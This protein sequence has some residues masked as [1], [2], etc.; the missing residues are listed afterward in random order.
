[1][2]DTGRAPG[3]AAV[4]RAPAERRAGGFRLMRYFTT[5]TLV[6]F[7]AVALTLFFLQRMEEDFFEQVQREHLAYLAQ[8][9][10][11]L[12]RQNEDA[13]RRSLLAE[14]EA[15]HVT[16]AQLVANMLWSSDI[17]PFVAQAR[18]VPIEHC[19]AVPGGAP[20]SGATA[21]PPD[22]RRTCF[23]E[24]GRRIRA[25]SGF[26][27]LDT[28]AYAAMRGS[29]V[30]KVKVFDLRGITVYSSEH[31]Q[32]GEDA[33]DNQGWRAAVGGRPAS[34]LTRRDKF[35]AFERVV[36]NR[37]LIST[38]VPLRAGGRDE[39]VGVLEIYA[40]VT[41]LLA[42]IKAASQRFAEA[43]ATNEATVAQ[44]ARA[45]QD[46][47]NASSNRFL[48]I[49]GGLLALLYV[50]SL[51]IVHFGQRII[52]KQAREH[53]HSVRREQ[54]WH[55]EKMAALATMAA[56]VSHEVGNPL[57]I[58]SGL[59]QELVERSA[60]GEPM[61]EP[62]RR[63]LEQ[64]TRIARMSRQM[65]DFAAARSEVREW[66][67]VNSM[68]KAVC[69][70]M[71]FDRRFR[72]TSIDFRPGDHLP[73]REIVPDHL[74]EVMMNLLQACVERAPES[75]PCAWIRLE[76][77]AR[78]DC[79][80]IRIAWDAAPADAPGFAPARLEP[81]RR[82][83]AEMGG[84]LAAGTATLEIKLP[85]PPGAAGGALP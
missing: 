33:V 38:Y 56:N 63:I 73:A 4:A 83:V 29:T 12:V 7:A 36:E 40:D 37:D 9:Q 34:E 30:F 64:T 52:D 70:F 47:V 71:G 44:S 8:S 27:A 68:L 41:P 53:E 74:N 48:A 22:A 16:L 66:V 31:G 6:A 80:S 72:A 2:G 50:A 60:R 69:E 46:K 76:T 77:E 25:L 78:D 21:S 43:V 67:D 81:V 11:Q 62:A 26:K 24:T 57:A 15:S 79:V 20:V 82:R 61:V 3:Q 42:Q 32:I 75:A 84:Q 58:I 35:S 23:A 51:M 1:M 28:K 14:H 18:Q 65:A 59:A 54:H 45:N 5:T 13:A 39:I 19:R 85:A 10:T 55:R 17:A 49:V